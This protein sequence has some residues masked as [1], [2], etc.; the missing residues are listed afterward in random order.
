[1]AP[2]DKI[3]SPAFFSF[4]QEKNAFYA[5]FCDS[6]CILCTRALRFLLFPNQN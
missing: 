1:M 3:H 5:N 4:I 6:F 2:I